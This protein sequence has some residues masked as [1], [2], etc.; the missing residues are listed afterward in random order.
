MLV[1]STKLQASILPID[2]FPNM[3][4]IIACLVKLP[5]IFWWLCFNV[6]QDVHVMRIWLKQVATESYVEFK[7]A[8]MLALNSVW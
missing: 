7:I 1:F 3:L 2:D 4:K 6:N 8:E 5:R